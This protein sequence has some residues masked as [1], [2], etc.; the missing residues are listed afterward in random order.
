MPDPLLFQQSADFLNGC[1]R[2]NNVIQ[3]GDVLMMFFAGK[4]SPDITVTLVGR[5]F[6]LR[7]GCPGAFQEPMICRNHHAP[8]EM[9]SQH[10]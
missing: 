2:S 7:Q 9:A 6:D 1:A 4:C 3:Q 8:A 5:Q 10:G